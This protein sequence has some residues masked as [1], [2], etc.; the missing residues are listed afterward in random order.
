MP[1]LSL[2]TRLSRR[3]MFQLGA[4]AAVSGPV[5][6]EVL[7]SKSHFAH[8][9]EPPSAKTAKITGA[10]ELVGQWTDVIPGPQPVIAVH[11]ALLHTGR[12][13]ILE[14]LT[15]YTWDP[16]TNATTRVDPPQNIFCAGHSALENGDILCSG[17]RLGSEGVNFGP[18]WNY[19]FRPGSGQWT[20]LPDSRK[21]RW[22]PSVTTLPDGRALITAGTDE[23]SNFNYDVEIYKKGKLSLKG[24]HD[25][26][27]YPG[28]FVLPNGKI[29]TVS[30][31]GPAATLNLSGYRWIPHAN[32]G[33]ARAYGCYVLL[34]GGPGGSYR[35]MASG[36]SH[37]AGT[38]HAS[39]QIFDAKRPLDGWRTVAPM[40]E[41]RIFHNLVILPDGDLCGV[42]GMND[43]EY[44]RHAL[45]YRPATDSWTKM[46]S[47][48]EVRAY[49]S[50]AVLLP[51]GRV[52]SAGDNLVP[53]GG[54][55]TLE[56]FSPPYL[57][58]GPRP[59]ITGAPAAVKAKRSF[60]VGTGGPVARVVLVRL[61]VTTHS[62]DMDQR[63]IELAF[64]PVEG[65]VK[66]KIP[67]NKI[68]VPGYYMLFVLNGDGVPSVARFVQVR[69]A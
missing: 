15:A 8:A 52:L 47:Q 64:K 12:V 63:H 20:R 3:Q 16:V 45:L 7:K 68:A 32:M 9:T 60:V 5:A 46:S 2:P 10:P 43:D 26:A 51:D 53:P 39:N 49:H 17:G 41:A 50:T 36:G 35:V 33:I 6:A 34:P 54:G 61:G 42:G 69:K 56:I 58:R 21:G 29:F 22:Y 4:A 55:E 30:P 28:Q 65:G 66:A 13:L 59:V 38:A 27:F 37:H 23:V 44:V 19:L 14:G 25:L 18:R 40:P 11:L 24:Q 57:F 1:P 48:N 31:D 62:F 67:S